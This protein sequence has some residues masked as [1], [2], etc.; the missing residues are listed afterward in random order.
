MYSQHQQTWRKD[1]LHHQLFVIY[2]FY[3]KESHGHIFLHCPFSRIL[4]SRL[5]FP[6]NLDTLSDT[7]IIQWIKLTLSLDCRLG[8]PQEHHRTFLLQATIAIDHT[9]EFRNSKLEK[10]KEVNRRLSAY[11]NAYTLQ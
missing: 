2:V 5:T 6:L 8:R 3:E 1:F 4:W 9:R 11:D 10:M 7:T